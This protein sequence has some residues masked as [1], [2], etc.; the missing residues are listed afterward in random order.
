MSNFLVY[1]K[2]ILCVARTIFEST[3][4]DWALVRPKLHQKD[5]EV[6]LAQIQP[7]DFA[8]SVLSQDASSISMSGDL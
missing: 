8:K 7:I 6:V 5:H 3:S 1:A 4:P 2:I